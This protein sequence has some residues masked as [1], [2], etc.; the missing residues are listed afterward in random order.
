MER[1]ESYEQAA[2]SELWEEKGPTGI[3]IGPC[4]ASAKALGVD[5]RSILFTQRPYGWARVGS[6][7]HTVQA[8]TGTEME[9]IIIWRFGG[10]GVA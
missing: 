2:T 6:R 7:Q 10:M 3:A 8:S 1:G 5:H 9:L 4:V